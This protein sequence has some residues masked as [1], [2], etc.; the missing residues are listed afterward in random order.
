MVSGNRLL[1]VNPVDNTL[2]EIKVDGLI[3][4]NRGIAYGEN[5]IWLPDISSKTIY[6]VDP[7]Q[8]LV[9]LRIPAVLADSEGSIGVG[10]GSVWAVTTAGEGVTSKE[11]HTLSRFN[12]QSGV[13]EADVHLPAQGAAVIFVDGSAWVTGVN[14]GELYRIDPTTNQ[15]V[16]SIALHK[17]PRF[18]TEGDGAIWVVSQGDGTVERVDPKRNAVIATV[19]ADAAGGGGDIAFGEG[20]IWVVTLDRLFIKINASTNTVVGRYRVPPEEYAIGDAVR[21]GAGS[22]WSSGDNI[23]RMEPP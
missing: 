16:A 23:F 10:A 8:S 18:M 3:G 11:N 9:T 14:K 19:E 5:A 15:I 4:P 7:L 22:L 6:K 21:Y 2:A 20:H 13:L 17:R 1:Q 12:A